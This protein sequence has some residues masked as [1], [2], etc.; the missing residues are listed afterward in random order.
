MTP[1][2][3][4]IHCSATPNG[5]KYKNILDQMWQWHHVERNWRKIGYHVVIDVDGT[6]SNVSHDRRLRGL[7][8][9]GAGV[10]GH[11]QGSIHI[12]LVGTDRFNRVQFTKLEEQ[13]RLLR[14]TTDIPLHKVYGH[15]EYNPKK[16]CPGMRITDAVL[17]CAT[18]QYEYIKEYIL[19]RR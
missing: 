13:I 17:F 5:K 11:N 1:E 8:E 7:N 16:T 6:V 14:C 12:C 9:V 3:I 19:K 4:F 18:G 15:Y 2:R 10:R